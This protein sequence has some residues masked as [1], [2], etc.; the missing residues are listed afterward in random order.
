MSVINKMLKDL[1]Q[2]QQGHQLS[3]I[4]QHQVQY[5][6][7]KHSVNIWVSISLMSLLI[8]GVGVYGYQLISQMPV[9][10]APKFAAASETEVAI[11][12]TVPEINAEAETITSEVVNVTEPLALSKKTVVKA[13]NGL[14]NTEMPLDEGS[15]P[16]A[17][18]NAQI[19]ATVTA[20]AQSEPQT[21]VTEEDEIVEAIQ[22]S[23]PERE[24]VKPSVDTPTIEPVKPAGKM[25]VTEV[26]LTPSQLAQKQLTL[27]T[28]AEK[29]GK[30]DKALEYYEK[31]LGFDPSL[32]NV[33]Q[34]LAAL[35]YGQGR[36]NNAEQV[37]QQAVLLYPQ[38]FEF[39]LLLARVQQELGEV[40]LA[41]ASLA[42]IPDSHV[43]AR[44][45]WLAQTDLAQKQGQFTLAEQA[46]RQLLQ[47]EPQQGKW[48][49][50]LGYALDSQQ[51]FAKASQAYRTALSH[52]GLSAQATAFI[53]QRLSQL[54]DSQ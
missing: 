42:Q 6:G 36:L 41:L 20:N 9:E 18:Q 37:L 15:H 22:A 10:P 3:N 40:D 8:G 14:V 45:K 44:Q 50:G 30:L 7:R 5:L 32:H 48:W 51:Q 17:K 27:A 39:Y 13:S 28:D 35:H 1:D 25:A 2:R 23:A 29:Q 34:Q 49:M 11:I 12:P 26:K 38:E 52:S 47:Q 24:F 19:E 46:Y 16:V 54:G 33:R 31:A 4:A 43:L 21:I 53:E